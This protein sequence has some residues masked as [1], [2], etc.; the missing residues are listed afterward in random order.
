MSQEER[1]K[2]DSPN[3][4]KDNTLWYYLD[5]FYEG[6]SQKSFLTPTYQLDSLVL[7]RAFTE[8]G[9]IFKRIIQKQQEQLTQTEESL[10]KLRREVQEL[11]KVV[12]YSERDGHRR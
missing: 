1:S 6:L 5:N 3:S 10:A 9:L 4:E 12:E 7:R 8:S 11:R 2:S